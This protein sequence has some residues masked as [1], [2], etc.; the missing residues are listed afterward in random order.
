MSLAS[1]ASKNASRS[2]YSWVRRARSASRMSWV[3]PG[4]PMEMSDASE[5][6]SEHTRESS[7]R[8]DKD[9]SGEAERRR[10]VAGTDIL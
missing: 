9:G 2:M 10:E 8:G 6:S 3:P 7:A 4:D 5:S 1:S